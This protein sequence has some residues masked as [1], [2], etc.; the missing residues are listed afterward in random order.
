MRRKLT[1]E[2]K[3]VSMQKRK[4]YLREYRKKNK[5]LY[6]ERTKRWQRENPIKRR[7]SEIKTNFKALD[8]EEQKQV[9]EEL[10]TLLKG[11]K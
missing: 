11:D 5:E 2:E 3:I 8:L 7:K 9:L 6:C 4:E 1:E 10:K